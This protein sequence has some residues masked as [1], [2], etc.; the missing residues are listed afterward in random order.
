MAGSLRA[1]PDRPGTWQLR[2]YLGRDS[3]G[4]VRHRHATFKGSR[5]AAER[6]LARLVATQNAEPGK[7]LTFDGAA[8]G[9]VRFN[10][11]IEASA[12]LCGQFDSDLG[13]YLVCNL[14]EFASK[15]VDGVTNAK[16]GDS[17]GPVF[18]EGCYS[19]VVTPYGII[20]AGS[21]GYSFATFLQA[22]LTHSGTTIYVTP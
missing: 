17:G 22:D 1:V 8:T 2:V 9:T 14:M 7:E 10:K 12:D 11:V 19:G 20:D 18:C 5:R 3:S 16:P 13:E 15:N 4:R 6:E 21:P